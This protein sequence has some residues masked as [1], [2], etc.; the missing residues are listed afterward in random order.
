MRNTISIIKVSYGRCMV[1][2][3]MEQREFI[4]TAIAD[5]TDAVSELQEEKERTIKILMER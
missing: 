2:K 3:N 5:I 1:C 4:K